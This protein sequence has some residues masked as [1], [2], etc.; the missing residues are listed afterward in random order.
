MLLH[1]L[2]G[3][4]ADRWE[5]KDH[6]SGVQ[7]DAGDDAMADGQR[8]RR[9]AGRGRALSDGQI[10]FGQGFDL[11]RKRVNPTWFEKSLILLGFQVLRTPLQLN[12]STPST[13]Q[14]KN[15]AV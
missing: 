8:R 4:R 6:G 7:K 10:C 1:G 9:Q 15:Y 13:H 3:D 5:V 14:L 2:L 11:G 12:G